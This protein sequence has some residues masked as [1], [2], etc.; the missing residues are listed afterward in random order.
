MNARLFN[1]LL[2]A[3]AACTLAAL[4]L[5]AFVPHAA[6]GWLAA[7]VFCSSLPV[8]ALLLVMMMRLIPGGWAEELGGP[9]EDLLLLLPLSA[10]AAVPVLIFMGAIYPWAG[11]LSPSGFQGAYL[12]GWFFAVRTLVFFGLCAVLAI[13]LLVRRQWSVPV[14]CTGLIVFMPAYT[15][16]ATDW[17]MSLEPDF[18]SSG[19]ALYALSIQANVALALIVLMR[20]TD[21][22]R[23]HTGLLGALLLSALLLWAYFAFMQYF[24]SWSDDLPHEVLWY[25]SRG[26]GAWSLAEYA[27]GLL[28]LGPLL[29]LLFPPVRA[30]RGMLAA[31]ALS[32]ILGKA[33]ELVWLVLPAGGA[34]AGSAG[35]F[36][37]GL[38]GLGALSI[39]ALG[40]M[41][42]SARAL[43]TRRSGPEVAS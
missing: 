25:R 40:R 35:A 29:A 22:G 15:A 33:I 7:F 39:A 4:A 36:L 10:V 21:S 32:V 41:V 34:N 11:A 2:A 3:G 28:G 38:A 27:L 37:L 13:L 1:M 5:L 16:I 42:P 30:S 17:L 6:A 8:G 24:I 23:A 12:T 19:F 31:L 18:H 43:L 14:S 9:A 20:L 26:E